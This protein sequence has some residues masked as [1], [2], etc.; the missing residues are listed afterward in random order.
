MKRITVIVLL[1]LPFTICS[2]K[3]HREYSGFTWISKGPTGDQYIEVNSISTADYVPLTFHFLI[4]KRKNTILSDQICQV[5]AIRV[6]TLIS[7]IVNV[8][9]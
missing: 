2:C 6:S 4:E 1:L 8:G 7:S 5:F 3:G 9:T